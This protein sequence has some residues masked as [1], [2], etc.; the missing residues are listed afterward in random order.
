MQITIRTFLSVVDGLNLTKITRDLIIVNL[1]IEMSQRQTKAQRK[2]FIR[3]FKKILSYE[4][5]MIS[6]SF[7]FLCITAT[8][9][10]LLTWGSKENLS[11]T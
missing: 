8:F 2:L 6:T 7:I 5:K 1:K 10:Q 9:G 3:S 4:L 11:L